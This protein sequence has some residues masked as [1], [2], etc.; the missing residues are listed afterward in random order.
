MADNRQKT[1][2]GL[3]HGSWIAIFF[4]TVTIMIASFAWSVTWGQTLQQV[5]SNTENI[6]DIKTEIK[7]MKNELITRMVKQDTVQE[8]RYLE[9]NRDI[10]A[11]L[12]ALK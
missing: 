2:L 6:K 10:K 1:K 9:T 12:R 5:A 11:I 3:S 7:E 8:K 4:S